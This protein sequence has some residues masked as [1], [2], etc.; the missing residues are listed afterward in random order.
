[1]LENVERFCA[2]VER[3]YDCVTEPHAWEAVINGVGECLGADA[4][5]LSIRGGDTVPGLTVVSGMLVDEDA[6]SL[7]AAC[8]G[9]RLDDLPLLR[10][11]QGAIQCDGDLVDADA[12]TDSVLYRECLAPKG[13][14]HVF[15]AVPFKDNRASA[16]LLFLRRNGRPA[17]GE[18]EMTVYG[19][20]ERHVGKVLTILHHNRGIER[21]RRWAYQALDGQSTGVLMLSADGR[22][23]HMNRAARWLLERRVG[24]ELDLAGHCQATAPGD[25][26]ELR[27]IIAAAAG[28]PSAA[29]GGKVKPV[30]KGAPQSGAMSLTPFGLGAGLTVKAVPLDAMSDGYAPAGAAVILY[31]CD[32]GRALSVRNGELQNLY[33]LTGA[34]ARL[35]EALVAGQS[36]ADYADVTNHSVHTIRT[37]MKSVMGKLDVHSQTDVVRVVLKSIAGAVM[38]AP[39]M[40]M[41]TRA[42]DFMAFAAPF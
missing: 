13:F 12:F 6:D 1:M 25:N 37:Q 41:A 16:V 10:A 30:K 32:A 4:T 40:V 39:P 11:G 8:E 18:Q 14:H 21:E 20:L 27:R 2:V 5:L 33:G 9:V 28:M 26:K 38:T 35:V 31:V 3:I 42:V 7:K 19:A 23:L 34:E 36:I 24:L 15:G 22:V 17:F 29:E